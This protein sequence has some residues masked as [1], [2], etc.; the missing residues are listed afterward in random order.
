MERTDATHPASST[1]HGGNVHAMLRNKKIS[2]SLLIDFSANINPLGPPDWLR[3]VISRQ[4]ENL[5]HYPDPDNVECVAAAAE[6]Y[7][8]EPEHVI[9]ANGTTEL[10]YLLPRVLSCSR[11][12]I[13]M[14]SYIDYEKVMRQ[15]GLTIVPHILKPESNFVLNPQ[16]LAPLLQGD[17]VVILGTPNNPTGATVDPGQLKNLIA[18]F[19]RT[20]FVIDEAF[21]DFM[22]DGKSLAGWAEN[23]ITLNSLTKFYAIPGLRLGIGVFPQQLS[24]QL[25]DILPPWTVN[26]IAQAVGSRLFGDEQYHQRSLETCATLRAGLERDLCQIKELRLFPSRV[27]YFL[28]QIQNGLSAPI[29]A[30]KLINKG[31]AIRVCDNYQGLDD[32]YFRVA[33][34]SAEENALLIAALQ[35]IFPYE[36]RAK[37]RPGKKARSIMFQGTSSNAGKS[38][39]T[40]ALCRILLQDGVRVAPFKAQNMSLN[41][42][43]TANGLEMG[44]AQVVQAQA[45][46]LDADVHMN[47]VLLKPNSDTGSQ[48]IIHGKP[49]GNMTVSHYVSY[50]DVAFQAARHSYDTLSSDYDVLVLEG[51]GSPGEVNLKSHDIVNMRMARYAESPVLLVGDIDR[52]GIYASFIGTLEVLAEWERQLVAGFVVNRFRGQASLLA[53]AHDYTT[54]YTGKDV[55]GVIPYLHSLGIPEEDSV[56]FKE[57]LF[58]S[59]APKGEHVQIALINLPHISNFTDIEPF[60]KEPD[61]HLNIV[62]TPAELG[63]P[64]AIILPGSKNVMGDMAFLRQSGLGDAIGKR[65]EKGCEIV[66]ICGGYQM[67]GKMI[68]DPDGIESSSAA[69]V[70]GLGLLDITTTLAPQKQLTRRQGHHVQ[71]G[72]EVRGY[73]IHHGVSTSSLEPLFQFSDALCCGTSSRDGKIWGSYLHGKFDADGFRRWFIDR[74]RVHAQLPPLKNIVAPYDLEPAFDRLAATV[75]DN[76]DMKRIYELLGL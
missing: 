31:I 34:R 32:S 52:G 72:L 6:F 45:A 60:I 25:K 20:L 58:D 18:D 41:S 73:E 36:S 1:G 5:V 69:T 40:A 28:L 26:T 21:L 39:L 66:G 4:I 19:P 51:A 33:V 29:L 62:K 57:G 27:N 11:A 47:P 3:P 54:M 16:E 48:V 15:A 67:L 38:V 61:V 22:S 30:A 76:M 68:T 65:A 64:D 14:P 35:E 17:E 44:R 53:A 63:T 42:F 50:K 9:A 37:K 71:S 70:E 49:V 59:N 74:L 7:K 24:R 43:V 8:V 23:V 75:R 46:R 55:L 12:I 10:L 13:P 2:T 56:S